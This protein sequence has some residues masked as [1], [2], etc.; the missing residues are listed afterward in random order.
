MSQYSWNIDR[1]IWIPHVPAVF[2]ES[3]CHFNFSWRWRNAP[4]GKQ[5]SPCIVVSSRRIALCNSLLRDMFSVSA[6]I[7]GTYMQAN[8][9]RYEML[10]V[11]EDENEDWFLALVAAESIIS[12]NT[13]PNPGYGSCWPLITSP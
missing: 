9:H 3:R 7:P 12:N 5:R 8:T 6:Y 4:V 13:N 1:R 10:V 11:D 2:A